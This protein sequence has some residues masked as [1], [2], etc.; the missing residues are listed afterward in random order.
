MFIGHSQLVRDFKNL[1]KSSRLAHGYIFFGEPEVGK[2]YFAKH[3]ASF[4]ENGEFE[5]YERPLQDAL[6]LNDAGA[7]G[8][9]PLANSGQATSVN[10]GQALPRVPAGI[11][12]MRSVKKFLWQRPAISSKR[13]VI[14]NNAVNLTT[15]AQNAI[16]K[17]TEEPPEHSVLILIANQTDN[18]I[19]PLFSRL[20][21]IY[22][23]R[24]SEDEMLKVINDKKIVDSAFGRPGLAFRLRND[25]LT[26]DAE[27]KAREFLRLTG[28]SRSKF[29]KELVEEQK[30]T[31]EILDLFFE[32]LI[33]KLK[34]DK[35]KNWKLLKSVLN[36]FFLI[37]SYN[38]NKRL[39]IEAISH[40]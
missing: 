19:P 14:I 39:Q 1:A 15:Q 18:L 27:Q 10:S 31:P 3:L 16:L 38:T 35:I 7:A 4:L 6:I 25:L 11:D 22:F 36:R 5:I 17:I 32:A 28:S 2:F 12:A 9:I 33:L 26:K 13:L 34:K 37:K 20:Q 21:R 23:G 29:I 24:L 40:Y 8:R 30:K